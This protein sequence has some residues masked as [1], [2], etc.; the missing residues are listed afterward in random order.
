MGRTICAAVAADPELVFVAGVDPGSV[1]ET[2]EGVAVSEHLHAFAD[3][4]CDVV[5]DFTVAHAART[6]LPW[7]GMHGIHAVV[8]TTGFS[9]E[10]LDLFESTFGAADGPNCVIAPNFAISAVLMMRF[11]EMAAPW[12]DTAEII[13]LHHDR[14]IDAPSGTAV[15]TAERMA[16]ARA[17]DFDPDPTEVEVYPGARGSGARRH[18]HPL[19]ADARHGRPSRG[20]PRCD[21]PDA[22]D[23]PGQLRPRQLHARRGARLQTHRRDPR[24]DA[25]PRPVP[26]DG[27]T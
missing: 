24:P 18:P 9:A 13:E 3:A 26:R 22:D 2:I 20:D 10:D 11:A 5:V 14:K 23:P 1:G 4:A 19:G 16:A 21:R 15:K 12:F 7:L 27:S 17:H 8:G 6:T 25:I